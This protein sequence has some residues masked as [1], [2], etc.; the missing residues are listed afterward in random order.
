MGTSGI[1]C[2]YITR[3]HT[4][5][6]R[7]QELRHPQRTLRCSQEKA[8]GECIGLR[9]THTRK[10]KQGKAMRDGDSVNTA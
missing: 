9:F 10:G 7:L 8:A 1:A 5:M 6:C 3:M 4:H 2:L